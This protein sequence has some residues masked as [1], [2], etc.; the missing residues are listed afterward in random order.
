MKVKVLLIINAVI[1][2]LYG[3]IMLLIPSQ[4]GSMYGFNATPELIFVSRLLGLY[5]FA[6][7]LLSWL[8]KDAPSSEPRRAVL[9]SFLA[10]DVLGFVVTLI[11]QLNGVVNATGWS[12][13]VV[14]LLLGIGFAYLLFAKPASPQERR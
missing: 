2:T 5:L 7:G 9:F 13:V 6:T 4:F 12:S 10:M 14:Y 11:Y 3:I 1:A 8:I